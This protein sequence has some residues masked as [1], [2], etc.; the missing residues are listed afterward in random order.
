MEKHDWYVPLYRNGS[1]GRYRAQR[2]KWATFAGVCM[3]LDRKA[4]WSRKKAEKRADELNAAQPAQ[5][6][7]GE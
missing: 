1:F 6:G 4:F 5:Q 3:T 7:A 2:V